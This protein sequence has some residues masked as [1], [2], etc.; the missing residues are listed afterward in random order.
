MK[1]GPLLTW[2]HRDPGAD[3]LV[4]TNGWPHADNETYCVFIKRQTESLWRKGVRCDVLFIRGYRSP[5]AYPLAALRFAFWSL[6]RR[7]R[8]RVVHAH[9]GEAALAAVFY[10][11]APLLSSY[12]GDD[13]LGSPRRDASVSL[14]WRV[15]RFVIRQQT[16]LSARTITKSRE[17]EWTLPRRVRRR[18]TV[19]P[20][21]VNTELFRPINREAA[22]LQLGWAT[23]DRIVLFAGDPNLPRKRYF[24]AQAAVDRARRELPNLKLEVAHRLAP[25]T[26]PLFMNA[27]DCLLLT[28]SVEGSPNVVKEALMCNLPVVAS[29]SGDV[30]ELLAGVEP[31]FICEPSAAA[32]ADGL[33]ECLR[34]PRRSNGRNA[35]RRLDERVVADTLVRLYRDLAPELEYGSAGIEFA[36][37]EPVH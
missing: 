25:D 36:T 11:R 24:L 21:G 23:R 15:R 12:L 5:L 8:Y 20:N 2:E 6:S 29:P 3:V 1:I 13:L 32:L 9:G 17:M 35:S 28:S 26:I 7:P 19:L 31:S 10:R 14:Q 34:E 33:V 27:A 16:R 22:R 4:V 37:T 30:V 18:N